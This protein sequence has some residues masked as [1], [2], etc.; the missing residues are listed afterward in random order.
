PIS[1]RKALGFQI[2][3]IFQYYWF[4]RWTRQLA[5]FVD[6]ESGEGRMLRVWPGLLMRL[7]SLLGWNP[8]FKSLRLFL[9]FALGIYFTRKLRQVVPACEPVALDSW[10]RLNFTMTFGVGAALSFVLLCAL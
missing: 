9:I 8:A 10:H 2:I 7:S 4:F 1:P 5:K 6:A 3:P